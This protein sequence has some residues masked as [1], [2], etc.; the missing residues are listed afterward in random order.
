MLIVYP[1]SI[2]LIAYEFGFMLVLSAF[3]LY[4]GLRKEVSYFGCDFASF[5]LVFVMNVTCRIISVKLLTMESLRLVLQ[6]MGPMVFALCVIVVFL[7][8]KKIVSV[9]E[10]G[11]R[12]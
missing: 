5:M 1:H 4:I 9:M 10:E 3:L 11:W 7:V 2:I 6:V 12:K 8:V